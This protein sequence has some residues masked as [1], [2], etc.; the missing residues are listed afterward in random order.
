M[1]VV[2]D[3]GP[4]NYLSLIGHLEV[5]PKLYGQVV[6]PRAVAEELLR[7]AGPPQL[8]AAL[9]S[10]PAWLRIDEAP[11][12][13]PSLSYLGVGEQQA[14]GLARALRADLLLC[15]DKE[16][17]EAATRFGLRVAGTLGVIQQ[18]ATEGMLELAST[19]QHLQKTNFRVSAAL[20]EQILRDSTRG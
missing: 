1:I 11:E 19:L 13:D 12:G 6:I 2:A 14:I 3:T 18:A 5:L 8:G 9:A 7:P 17:R 15:D 16:A 4:L 10:P 20:I